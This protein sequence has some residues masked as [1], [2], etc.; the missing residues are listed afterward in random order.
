MT[1]PLDFSNQDLRDLS[2][3]TAGQIGKQIFIAIELGKIKEG[4]SISS[5]M[6]HNY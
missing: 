1:Q 2:G 5:K 6:K 4:T 3:V